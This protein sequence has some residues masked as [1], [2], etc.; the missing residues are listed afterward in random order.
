MNEVVAWRQA[1][2]PPPDDEWE[3]EPEPRCPNCGSMSLVSYHPFAF[4][5]LLPV[6][7]PML[8]VSIV[9]LPLIP[10]F[11][12]LLWVRKWYCASCRHRWK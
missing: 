9:L 5:I 7:L 2:P 8:I 1:E 12:R 11:L 4:W 3:D 6:V 10:F